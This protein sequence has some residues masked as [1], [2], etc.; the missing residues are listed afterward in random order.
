MTEPVA[1]CA[2]GGPP[3]PAWSPLGWVREELAGL[4]RESLRRTRRVVEPLPDGQCRIDRRT[5]WNFA[6]ND[7]LGLASHPAVRAAALAAAEKA[8]CGAQAS[9]LVSG[10]TPLHAEL[11][12]RLAAFEGEP[13]AILFPSGFAA[14]TGTIP[15]L[16]GSDDVVLCDRLNHASLVD[17]CRL[18]GARLRVYSYT[19][20]HVLERELAKASE[21][22]RR[23]IVTDSVF[24]MDGTL[25]PLVEIDRLARRYRALVVVDEAHATGVY[26]TRG[27]GV[28]E[29]LGLTE[30]GF[31]RIGTLS[32]GIGAQG[33]FV[34]GSTD[35]IDWLTNRART[36]MYSTGLALPTV[37]AALASLDLLERDASIRSR[38]I[39][40]TEQ[41]RAALTG[42]GFQPLG[43]DHCPIV[44]V[45]LH[46][47]D[48]TI[49]AARAL[50]AEGFLVGAI[51]PPTVP[52]GTSRL[53]ITVSAAHSAEAIEQLAAAL[54]R[55]VTPGT[56][57][58]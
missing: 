19:E 14:N 22:R 5:L 29:H 38:L 23:V 4:E 47:P 32:K 36:Q 39:A 15:A 26:G 55:A 2:D 21:A 25:A 51:R 50:E 49:A 43:D 24:S 42:R 17:G 11:E 46:D 12:A 37:A 48:R 56:A 31:V 57:S 18:S 3:F 52:R 20:L 41:L 6:G 34:A 7:Y 9:P 33:G 10:R 27:T 8:G 45:V 1:D 40:R 16:A 44:P 30:A 35:L 58:P 28:V 54:A 53:R 13:A